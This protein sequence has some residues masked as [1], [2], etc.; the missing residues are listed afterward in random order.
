MRTEPST[1]PLPSIRFCRRLGRRHKTS[2]ASRPTTSTTSC[3][4]AYMEYMIRNGQRKPCRIERTYDKG[5]I[6]EETT[7]HESTGAKEE[8]SCMNGVNR[9]RYENG[10]PYRECQVVKGLPKRQIRRVSPR[11]KHCG[12]K[13]LQKRR[14]GRASWKNTMKTGNSAPY[15]TSRDGKLTGEMVGYHPDGR[16]AGK[17]HVRDTGRGRNLRTLLCQR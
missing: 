5:I 16:L 3:K 7:W 6:I 1:R 8:Y 9:S 13:L 11:R 12:D 17:I 10:K 4:D 2:P 15:S 14:I